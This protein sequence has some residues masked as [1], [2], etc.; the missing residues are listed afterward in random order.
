MI[1]L[2]IVKEENDLLPDDARFPTFKLLLKLT[3]FICSYTR[4]LFR[5]LF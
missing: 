2:K 5:T 3:L 4:N 1:Q